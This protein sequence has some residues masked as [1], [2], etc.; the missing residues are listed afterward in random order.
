METV[1]G[2]LMEQRVQILVFLAYICRHSRRRPHAGGGA[3]ASLGL[4]GDW[5]Q[6]VGSVWAEVAGYKPLRSTFPNTLTIPGSLCK[7]CVS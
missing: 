7:L 4:P 6:N 5:L 2:L 3:S 1:I